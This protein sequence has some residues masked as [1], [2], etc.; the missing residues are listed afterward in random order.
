M[1]EGGRGH[2]IQSTVSY[3][4]NVLLMA[5]MLAAMCCNSNRGALR[6]SCKTYAERDLGRAAVAGRQQQADCSSMAGSRMQI[7]VSR[8][9][10]RYAMLCDMMSKM[11]IVKPMYS[12]LSL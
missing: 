5:I 8:P 2:D 4:H 7:A 9:V 3:Q 11:S 12:R 6:Y 1:E 10:V